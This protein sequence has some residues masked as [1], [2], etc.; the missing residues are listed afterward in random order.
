MHAQS[1]S[2]GMQGTA[3]MAC[4][5]VLAWLVCAGGLCAVLM[6]SR[7]SHG[8]TMPLAVTM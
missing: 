5:C 7:Q 3:I 4:M 2:C 8:L 1:C 6:F